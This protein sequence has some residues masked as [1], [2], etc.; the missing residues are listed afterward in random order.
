MRTFFAKTTDL[1]NEQ[2]ESLATAVEADLGIMKEG[3]K[4]K[5]MPKTVEYIL[6]LPEELQKSA[7]KGVVDWLKS[8][9]FAIAPEHAK[10]LGL[11]GKKEKDPYGVQDQG[12]DPLTWMLKM[13]KLDDYRGATVMHVRGLAAAVEKDLAPDKELNERTA[14]S[15]ENAFN[16]I[17][18]FEGKPQFE[19]LKK[20]LADFLRTTEYELDPTQAELL[21]FDVK[22]DGAVDDEETGGGV[23]DGTD[24]EDGTEDEEKQ[25]HTFGLHRSFRLLKIDLGK[26]GQIKAAV[27]L[28][29]FA[30]NYA[31]L[32]KKKG[33]QESSWESDWAALLDEIGKVKRRAGK[34]EE[35]VEEAAVRIAP[36]TREMGLNK[37]AFSL[38]QA[39]L[40]KIEQLMKSE[41]SPAGRALAALL[42][43]GGKV[44][45][46]RLVGAFL[47]AVWEN[48]TLG[49]RAKGGE[50]E[51]PADAEQGGEVIQMPTRAAAPPADD[52]RV[53]AESTQKSD[54]TLLAESTMNRWKTLSGI[55]RKS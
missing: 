7:T 15:F 13:H 6:S 3:R 47:A 37:K 11:G 2:V 49:G 52:L 19:G 55:K 8:T 30:E 34:D 26:K 44:G 25:K 53:A 50:E 9:E 20:L 5:E 12:K 36:M 48:I 40:R 18:K 23:D 28:D 43:G 29:Q 33:W 31:K 51:A 41:E 1:S 45:S 10:A 4:P 22:P 32:A 46:Y 39:R 14:K 27:F 24:D 54:D 16:F 21:G 17:S 42:A 38:L 35:A